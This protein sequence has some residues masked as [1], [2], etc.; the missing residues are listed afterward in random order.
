MTKSYSKLKSYCERRYNRH[1]KANTQGP[2]R[3][4][5][6]HLKSNRKNVQQKECPTGQDVQQA[7][8]YY[9]PDIQQAVNV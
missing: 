7:K 3:M 1:I 2:L 4:F 5:N 8:M 6:K 9:R